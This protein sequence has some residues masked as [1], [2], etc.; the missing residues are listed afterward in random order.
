MAGVDI[1]DQHRTIEVV[2]F[3]IEHL[4]TFIRRIYWEWMML[5]YFSPLLHVMCKFMSSGIEEDIIF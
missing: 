3:N 5:A 4:Q 2:F 1:D